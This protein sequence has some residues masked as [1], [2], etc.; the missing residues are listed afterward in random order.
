MGAQG[1][2]MITNITKQIHLCTSAPLQLNTQNLLN[3][4]LSFFFICQKMN[5]FPQK[6]KRTTVSLFISLYIFGMYSTVHFRYIYQV[7]IL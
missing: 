7:L 6:K 2:E 5:P 1:S 4:P 3:N